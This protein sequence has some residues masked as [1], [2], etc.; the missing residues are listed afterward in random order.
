M[1]IWGILA[2][3]LGKILT[4][5]LILSSGQTFAYPQLPTVTPKTF[6]HF[7]AY[8]T[9][10]FPLMPAS[11]TAPLEPIRLAE[12]VE[13]APSLVKPVA[14]APK[15]E[16]EKPTT[17]KPEP[18]VPQEP[19]AT[20]PALPSPAPPAE[21]LSEV[22]AKTRAALVNILCITQNSGSLRPISGSGII[23][24]PSG[25]ILT[26]A[27][28]A[29]FLLL[30]NYPTVGNVDCYIR[31]GNPASAMYRAELLYFPKSW[32]DANAHK[33]VADNPTGTGEHDF[34]LLR[35]T[36]R[37]DVSATLPASFPYV[38]PNITQDIERANV[39]LAGYP[40]GFL[41]G[42]T[43]Q[44]NL[45]LTSAR[46]TVGEIFTFTEGGGAELFSVGGT[47]LSQKGSSGGAVVRESDVSLIGL[48]ATATQADSTSD[49]D[50]RAITVYHIDKSIAEDLGGGLV[51]YLSGDLAQKAR[52]FNL[53]I[54]PTLTRTL[55]EAVER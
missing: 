36:G 15:P 7:P 20:A 45:F 25:V 9:L 54:A 44:T 5:L 49:R 29:Q 23:I 51:S 12:E 34:A 11:S 14:V 48:I 52:I 6:F 43:I 10:P 1:V 3:V 47:V 24:D 16:P 30:R 31:T 53:T 19:V 13:R 26:N 40:A 2:E 18:T 38:A 37:T 22:N 42:A 4:G 41:G 55:I 35:I 28:V 27:H 32:M 8:P 46:T 21:N 33:I 17:P 39:L 50:L